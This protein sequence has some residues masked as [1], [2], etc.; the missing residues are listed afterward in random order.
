MENQTPIV[1]GQAPSDEILEEIFT[2]ERLFWKSIAQEVVRG[3]VNRYLEGAKQIINLNGVLLGVYF[4]AIALSP[5]SDR[6]IIRSWWDVRWI[7]L[8]LIPALA[9]FAG[10]IFAVWALE[11]N[12]Y[13]YWTNDSQQIERRWKKECSTLSQHISVARWSLVLGFLLM[14]ISLSIFLYYM[15]DP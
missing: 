6:L 13:P 8:I 7:V 4:A 3:K 11:P 10:L 2:E 1:E 12:P 9:W 14:L 15:C 5:I